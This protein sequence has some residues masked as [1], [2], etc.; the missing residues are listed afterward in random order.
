MYKK[1]VNDLLAGKYSKQ[2][3][4]RIH[5]QWK[6]IE[7]TVTLPDY[8]TAMKLKT[9]LDGIFHCKIQVEYAK[10]ILIAL[11][12][13]SNQHHYLTDSL[14]IEDIVNQK[15]IYFKNYTIEYS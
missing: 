11:Y 4:K 7:G 13:C 8:N 2:S 3:L 14:L 12:Y 6:K 5:S 15:R 9:A 10:K 1:E